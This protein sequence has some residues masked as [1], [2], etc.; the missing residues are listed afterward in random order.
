[1]DLDGLSHPY[2]D[3]EVFSREDIFWAGQIGV[4]I[5]WLAVDSFTDFVFVVGF[6]ILLDMML[7]AYRNDEQL[8]SL[9]QGGE[10]QG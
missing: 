4:L 2:L 7:Y 3:K 8:I 10:N 6:W 1:V 5:G 9:K